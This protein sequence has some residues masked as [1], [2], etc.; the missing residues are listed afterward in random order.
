MPRPKK[1]RVL[2]GVVLADNL[3]S[4]NRDNYYRYLRPNGTA[5]YFTASS[6]T[7]ANELANEANELRG[8]IATVTG[9]NA[10]SSH[11]PAYIKYRENL[12]PR[13][14]LKTSWKNR[15][16]ALTSLGKDFKSTPLAKISHA[17]INN[18]WETLSYHQQKI[19]HA[20]FRRFFNW[21]MGQSLCPSL[22]Y[23]P[24]TTADDRPRLY[25]SGEPE[26]KKKRLTL[27][28]FWEVYKKAGDLDYECLQIAMGISLTTAMREGDICSLRIDNDIQGHF[29]KKAIGKS[30]AQK[31]AA[32][33]ARLSWRTDNYVLLRQLI[34]RGR[35]LSMKNGRCPF[36]ISHKPKQR[37]IGKTKIHG[38][39]VTPRRLQEM[40]TQARD[41][42]ELY[43]DLPNGY[44]P[45]TFHEVRSLFS[46][47][48]EDSKYDIKDIQKSMA[49]SN[50]STT[51][52]YQ[53]EHILPYEDA[54]I[55]FTKKLIGGDF[56]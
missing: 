48:A 39:Q 32:K 26:R 49:H 27:E 3:Y 1:R 16:Y 33:A 25:L 22:D 14:K 41:A 20:E 8:E 47:L 18:W 53:E 36:L 9:R 31:G 21:L 4:G 23:N 30:I 50:E 56:K 44:K 17:Q 29:L 38:S 35:E 10:L 51:R 2:K 52:L 6:V 43:E 24:F 7:E 34:T 15:G 19:R 55:V 40:F 37:R 5:K 11:I 46:K 12:N 54:P 13:L 42:T 28:A 45:P